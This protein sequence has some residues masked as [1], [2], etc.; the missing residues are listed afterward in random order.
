M[1]TPT[2][3]IQYIQKTIY[4]AWEE[5]R[6]G[7]HQEAPTLMLLGGVIHPFGEEFLLLL[8]LFVGYEH[9]GKVLIV[10]GSLQEC[11]CQSDPSNGLQEK[12]CEVISVSLEEGKFNQNWQRANCAYL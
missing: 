5:G 3:Y 10:V 9:L 4:M 7:E 11:V 1:F 12:M 8:G 2:F 6:A